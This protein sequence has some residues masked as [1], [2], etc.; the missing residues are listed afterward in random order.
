MEDK[1]LHDKQKHKSEEK[2]KQIAFKKDLDKADRDL[3]DSLQKYEQLQEHFDELRSEKEKI[4]YTLNRDATRLTSE[5]S[6][7]KKIYERE[8]MLSSKISERQISHQHE[9][10]SLKQDY[11]RKIGHLTRRHNEE[12]TSQLRLR[13]GANCENA[14]T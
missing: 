5:I 11:D 4:T 9:V 14:L 7:L 3:S 13:Q 2:E 8:E 1:F 10:A 6:R 12:K